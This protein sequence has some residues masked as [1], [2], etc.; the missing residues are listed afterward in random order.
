[1]CGTGTDPEETEAKGYASSDGC[2]IETERRMAET[3]SKSGKGTRRIIQ[4]SS[5]YSPND[6]YGSQSLMLLDG[7]KPADEWLVS[8]IISRNVTTRMD[9]TTFMSSYVMLIPTRPSAPIRRTVESPGHF[10]P[11]FLLDE[12][13][14]TFRIA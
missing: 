7:E 13:G 2:T 8:G 3:R 4:N 9:F 5:A 11:L 1:V 10:L 14:C 6:R 12:Y